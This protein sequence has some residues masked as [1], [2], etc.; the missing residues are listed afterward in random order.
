MKST[1]LLSKPTA[2][3]S[4]LL[5]LLLGLCVAGTIA[6]R[7][8]NLPTDR[9]LTLVDC[10]AA[11]L[12]KN[13]ALEAYKYDLKAADAQVWAQRSGLLPQLTGSAQVFILNGEPV[14]QFSVVG[15]TE[16][17]LIARHV[18]W[19]KGWIG[20][21]GLT[22]P[23]FENGS[24]F[25]V[26]N[27]PAV[28][29]AKAERK[30][31][32]WARSLAEQDAIY[33]VAEAYFGTLTAQAKTAFYERM[34]ELAKQRVTIVK[35]KARLDL[36]LTQD[37]QIAESRLESN[38]QGLQASRSKAQESNAYLARLIGVTG[39]VQL[40]LAAPPT[41]PSVPPLDTL[42][43][44]IVAKHPQ[45]GIQ[46]AI[47][48]KAKQD[49]R[50]NQSH[51][52]PSVR[53]NASYSYGSDLNGGPAP[54]LVAANVGVEMPLF[55]FGHYNALVRSSRE[56]LHAEEQRVELT[57]Y[58][59]RRSVVEAVGELRQDQE[60][61]A[62][63]QEQVLKL[64]LDAKAAKAK[65]EIGLFTPLSAVDTEVNL[66]QQEVLLQDAQLRLWMKYSDLQRT[67]GGVWKWIP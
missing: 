15:V 16:P 59:I 34:V 39:P 4:R 17:E 14:S 38:E 67:A 8:D 26:N 55:D 18:D 32:E 6:A 48:E 50:L 7:A 20:T 40:K 45:M 52:L 28:A 25:G 58:D 11:A 57:R 37:V 54:D 13:P 1:L 49:L 47:V 12:G 21:L 29:S 53:A 27:A 24:I 65:Q 22:Y 23:I 56:K 61:A 44:S 46:D 19:G 30:Q 60:E 3:K 64:Q 63:L 10:V 41:A 31:Q 62:S 66:L 43:E 51:R 35:E 5:A 9:P 42:L 2:S 33:T 36:A